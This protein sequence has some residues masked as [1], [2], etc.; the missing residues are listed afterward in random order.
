MVPTSAYADTLDPVEIEMWF[1]DSAER[2]HRL[3]AAI[4]GLASLP[5]DPQPE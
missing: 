1:H 3:K 5:Q 2:K 4:Q